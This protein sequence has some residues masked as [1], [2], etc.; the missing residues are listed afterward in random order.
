MQAPPSSDS[1][2]KPI[3]H[4]PIYHGYQYEDLNFRKHVCLVVWL[5]SGIKGLHAV[6]QRDGR[7]LE[8][9]GWSDPQFTNVGL[10]TTDILE[11]KAMED[12]LKRFRESQSDA[13]RVVCRLD[14]PV[15]VTRHAP[16]VQGAFDPSTG[17]KVV[18]VRMACVDTDEHYA[19]RVP[20]QYK[21]IGGKKRG[22]HETS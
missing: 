9:T 3:V 1:S 14:L 12:S 7:V 6:V 17:C 21:A 13:V 10:F 4:T 8:I 19:K 16:E 18:H 11:Q 5:P 15:E 2:V 22:R 20:V